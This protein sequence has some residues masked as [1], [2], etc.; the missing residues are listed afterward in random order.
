MCELLV[1]SMDKPAPN[2]SWK[3]GYVVQV[4]PDGQKW[5]HSEQNATFLQII[6]IP[7]VSHEKIKKT[8]EEPRYVFA[9]LISPDP[10][11]AKNPRIENR[12][13]YKIDTDKFTSIVQTTLEASAGYTEAQKLAVLE[14]ICLKTEDDSAMAVGTLNK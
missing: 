7:G 2:S 6:K 9:D 14:G 13:M 8:L 10:E 4:A 3:K 12:K 1:F 5:S 11:T